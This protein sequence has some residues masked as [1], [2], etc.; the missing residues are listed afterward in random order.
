MITDR[1]VVKYIYS[2]KE[3]PQSHRHFLGQN[4]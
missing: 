4:L 1:G 3:M 2:E